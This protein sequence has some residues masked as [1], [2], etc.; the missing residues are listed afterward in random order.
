MAGQRTALLLLLAATFPLVAQEPAAPTTPEG[1]QLQIM[2]R[3]KQR[4]LNA[5]RAAGRNGTSPLVLFRETYVNIAQ[6]NRRQFAEN[7][8]L[9]EQLREQAEN[10]DRRRLFERR[11]SYIRLAEL[12][13][14]YALQNQRVVKAYQDVSTSE[15]R[16]A[17]AEIEAIEKRILALGAPRPKRD[18]FTLKEIENVPLP[19]QPAAPAAGRQP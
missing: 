12:Y 13:R 4:I 1:R 2:Q 17:L 18:W 7:T 16:Q 9:V 8:R 3:E 14:L 15:M 5:R 11:D 6:G 10:A 19:G